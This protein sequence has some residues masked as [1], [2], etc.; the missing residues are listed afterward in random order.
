MSESYHIVSFI[1][2][3]SEKDMTDL[4][5]NGTIYMS[6]I[7]KFRTI[8]DNNLRGDNYEEDRKK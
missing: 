8:E 7:K 5:E 2:F 6:S 1:K 4:L 3:G